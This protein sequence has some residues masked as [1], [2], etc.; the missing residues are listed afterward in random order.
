MLFIIVVSVI[1]VRFW[2]NS[3]IVISMLFYVL[4]LKFIMLGLLSGLCISDWKIVL[5]MFSV[6][7][8]NSVISMCGKCYLVIIIVILCGVLFISV[9]NI[10]EV[11][12]VM[13]LLCNF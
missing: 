9:V 6:V 7:L 12:S 2:L 8:I 5:L 10:C 1:V 13:V 3:I 4:V 11:F